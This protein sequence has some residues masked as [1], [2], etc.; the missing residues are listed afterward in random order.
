MA[1]EGYYWPEDRSSDTGVLVPGSG[2]SR[3]TLDAI[4]ARAGIPPRILDEADVEH[5]ISCE[6]REP[7]WH[8]GWQDL[9]LIG[10]ED[11]DTV[12]DAPTRGSWRFTRLWSRTTSR[13]GTLRRP[14]ARLPMDETAASFSG[15][16]RAL[17]TDA[18]FDLFAETG[19]TSLLVPGR[20]ERKLARRS[21]APS[22]KCASRVTRCADAARAPLKQARR[23]GICRQ[24]VRSR[25]PPIQPLRQK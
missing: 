17:A 25:R 21:A 2:V 13:D 1:V 19:E 11:P 3:E 8:V 10:D 6:I 5:E 7:L 4:V 23:A 15:W 22:R 12:I 9:R 16:Q 14:N 24:S 20:K 18:H